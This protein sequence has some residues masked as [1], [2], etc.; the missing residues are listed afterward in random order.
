MLNFPCL[1]F[2]CSCDVF[3]V[4]PKNFMKNKAGFGSL[5]SKLGRRKLKKVLLVF[6]CSQINFTSGRRPYNFVAHY[7]RNNTK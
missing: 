4:S 6:G 7:N 2:V 5:L 1:N 3:Q